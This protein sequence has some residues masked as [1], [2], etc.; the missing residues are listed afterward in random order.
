MQKKIIVC[1]YLLQI[2]TLQIYLNITKLHL[3]AIFFA[4]IYLFLYFMFHTEFS[5]KLLVLKTSFFVSS[6][7]LAGA[8]KSVCVI[9]KFLYQMHIVQE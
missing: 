2:Y 7:N 1:G 5:E 6:S 4:F 9:L 8:C 3:G